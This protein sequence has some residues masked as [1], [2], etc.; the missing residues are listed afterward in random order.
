MLVR[1]LRSLVVPAVIA[2][3]LVACT[4]SPQA[5]ASSQESSEL[6]SCP[7]P[8]PDE[9]CGNQCFETSGDFCTACCGAS[10]EVCA[11]ATATCFDSCARGV[12]PWLPC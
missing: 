4:T 7:F 10:V 9:P 5:P 2:L 12:G 1:R 6:T 3:L 11:E 8:S